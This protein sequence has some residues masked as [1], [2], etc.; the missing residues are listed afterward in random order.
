MLKYLPGECIIKLLEKICVIR[1]KDLFFGLKEKSSGYTYCTEKYD[2]AQ[3]IVV[4]DGE[5]YFGKPQEEQRIGPGFA[6]LL[7]PESSFCLSTRDRGYRGVACEFW[8]YSGA[9]LYGEAAVFPGDTRMRLIAEWIEAEHHS[10]GGV[11]V[12]VVRDL[13]VSLFDLALSLLHRRTD[14]SAGTAEFWY[15]SRAR[16]LLEAYALTGAGVQEVLAA[17]PVSYRQLLRCFCREMGM[18]P[19]Q[20]QDKYRMGIAAKYLTATNR[21]VAEI[22]RELGFTSS[23]HFSQ[24]FRR[25]HGMS[26]GDF[27]RMNIQSIDIC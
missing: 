26:P 25:I 20:Y 5:L 1:E 13:C 7:M 24:T 15:V 23:Q 3:V 9:H 6:C 10:S 11:D 8:R 4:T 2:I 27:R 14:V 18:S 17:L 22:S 19:K 21:G 16:T 12:A